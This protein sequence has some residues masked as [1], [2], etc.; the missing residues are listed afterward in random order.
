MTYDRDAVKVW[1][2]DSQWRALQADFARFRLSAGDDLY[3]LVTV[4]SPLND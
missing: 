4:M 3:R 1:A 2:G